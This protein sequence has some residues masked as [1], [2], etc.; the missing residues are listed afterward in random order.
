MTITALHYDVNLN[1][2]LRLWALPIN[3][4]L[5][6]SHFTVQ[7]N[8]LSFRLASAV[9]VKGKKPSSSS[10][11]TSNPNSQIRPTVEIS[12]MPQPLP[13]LTP[14]SRSNPV[15]SDCIPP[16]ES[17]LTSD[18]SVFRIDLDGE[19]Q[20]RLPKSIADTLGHFGGNYFVVR[21][22][23]IEEVQGAMKDSSL[24]LFDGPNGSGKSVLLMQLYTS[25][26]E[27]LK[28]DAE[29]LLI[30][31]PNVHKWT[32]G[33]FSYYPVGGGKEFIQPELALEILRLMTICNPGKVPENLIAEIKEAELD[34]FNRALPLYERI[35]KELKDQGKELFFFMDGVNGLID[36]ESSTGYLDQEGTALPLKSLPLCSNFFEPATGNIK[37]ISAL[38][39]SNPALPK[40]S[41][42]P[43]SIKIVKVPNYS[44]DDLKRVLQL[45]GQLG[46]VSTNKSDQFVAFKAFVSGFNGRKLFKS[47]EYDSIYYKQ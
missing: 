5:Q 27:S 42:L 1:C 16:I 41:N 15:I 2:L 39:H 18:K 24:T 45:Y 26:R 37:I 36:K 44:Q 4:K 3:M 40:I 9:A 22:E 20:K 46:H 31:V 32:T 25:M 8:K 29:K 6:Y 30:Y 7:L 14:L 23:L 34:S 13:V 10:S 19:I 33:Y 12:K 21:K 47:C 28:S 17:L 43:P 11:T 38:T 35:I